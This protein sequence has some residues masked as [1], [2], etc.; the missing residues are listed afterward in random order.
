MFGKCRVAVNRLTLTQVDPT[1]LAE[2]PEELQKEVVAALPPSHDTFAFRGN[3]HL[4]GSDQ[5]MHAV[6]RLEPSPQKPPDG[7]KQGTPQFSSFAGAEASCAGPDAGAYCGGD[8]DPRQVWQAVRSTLEGLSQYLKQGPS[9][10]DA[11]SSRDMAEPESTDMCAPE[12]EGRDKAAKAE[13]AS[14]T[15]CGDDVHSDANTRKTEE[16]NIEVGMVTG[17]AGMLPADAPRGEEA[18]PQRQEEM[19]DS[20]RGGGKD[21]FDTVDEK[22]AALCTL[23]REWGE[24]LIDGNLEGLQFLLRRLVEAQSLF[25]RLASPLGCCYTALQA[26]VE[27]RLGGPIQL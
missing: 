7:S 26:R 3:L 10:E 11:P 1:V 16:D 25:P 20:E 22:L 15:Q 23:V 4:E 13:L 2:L 17:V 12:D 27:E 9:E 6:L 18:Q 14:Y 21:P 8:E 24:S 5:H 19:Q